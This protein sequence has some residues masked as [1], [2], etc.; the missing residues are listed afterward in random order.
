MLIILV[1]HHQSWNMKVSIK[2]S[3]LKALFSKELA[4]SPNHC[5]FDNYNDPCNWHF[6][7]MCIK[8]HQCEKI[9]ISHHWVLKVASIEIAPLSL[10]EAMACNRNGVCISIVNG[11]W[12]SLTS[13]SSWK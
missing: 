10:N 5:M 6:V 8:H 11:T 4:I 2:G 9:E 3:S 13:F 12:I 1:K 7:A